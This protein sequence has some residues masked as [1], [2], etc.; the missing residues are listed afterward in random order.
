MRPMRMVDSSRR[1]LIATAVARYNRGVWG[2]TG[3]GLLG[4][5]AL[6]S[7]QWLT[8]LM[9]AI[10]AEQAGIKL[11]D[12]LPRGLAQIAATSDQPPPEIFRRGLERHRAK[13]VADLLQ[14][15]GQVGFKALPVGGN[16]TGPALD[17]EGGFAVESIGHRRRV[18]RPIWLRELRQAAH[19]DPAIAA[20][21]SPHPNQ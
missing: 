10:I 8:A 14:Q 12:Q 7:L 18:H 20:L 21:K 16:K 5:L 2:Q 9:A 1:S 6:R 3:G 13:R 15:I 4:R 11:V 17:L 19:G